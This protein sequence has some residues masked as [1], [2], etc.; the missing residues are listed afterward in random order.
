MLQ[1][2]FIMGACLFMISGCQVE[3]PSYLYLMLHA[4]YLQKVYNEC[5]QTTEDRDLPC[6]SIM[7]AVHSQFDV[8]LRSLLA[9]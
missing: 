8:T 4:D 7:R 5:V 2:L 3:E 9:K 6:E 1:K